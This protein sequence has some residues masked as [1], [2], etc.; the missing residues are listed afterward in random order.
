MAMQSRPDE[1]G[2]VHFCDV[3]LEGVSGAIIQVALGSKPES[4]IYSGTMGDVHVGLKQT[5]L[6]CL[7]ADDLAGAPFGNA[8]IRC[9]CIDRKSL[10]GDHEAL[11]CPARLEVRTVIGEHRPV[12]LK[13]SLTPKAI[14]R[15]YLVALGLE[16]S[17]QPAIRHQ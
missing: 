4:I 7:L 1:R 16:S 14:F 11:C 17:A 8:M 12:F 13:C 2:I 5:I 15:R 6:K 10:V 9:N 3:D